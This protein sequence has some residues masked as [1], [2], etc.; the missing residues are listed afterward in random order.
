MTKTLQ[1]VL[2]LSLF[3]VTTVFIPG[4]TQAAEKPIELRLAH[5]FPVAA[6]SHQ[7]IEAWAKK[8]T[9]DSHGRLTVR[10]YPVNTLVP[11]PEL[12]DAVASG[13]ADISF[14]FRYTPKG[15]PLGVTFPFIL[16]APD[17]VTATKVYDDLWK[18][19]PSLW[20]KNGR[21]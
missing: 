4:M 7:L 12:V 9:T 3:I 21:T 1:A 16:G 15:Q 19:S 2:V 5:M 8:I 6:P 17:V 11:A 10:I 14:G 13:T 18:S 20:L